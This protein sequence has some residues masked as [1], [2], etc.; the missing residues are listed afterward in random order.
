LD[1]GPGEKGWPQTKILL[2]FTSQVSGVYRHI[3]PHPTGMNFK[4]VE[5]E[6]VWNRGR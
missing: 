4:F 5:K 1:W 3:P 2:I 6:S